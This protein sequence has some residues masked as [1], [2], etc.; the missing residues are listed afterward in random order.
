VVAP[1][2]F[3]DSAT[4]TPDAVPRLRA[5]VEQYLLACGLAGEIVG[6]VVLSVS[7]ALT[8]VVLHAYPAGK[9]GPVHV[10][11]EIVA[12][13]VHVVV[14]DEGR[15]MTPR[16]DSPGAGLGLPIIAKLASSVEIARVDRGTQLRMSFEIARA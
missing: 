10:D 3:R 4:A 14:A 8:N 15:G 11:T 13:V 16:H 12:G 9:A 5:A 7:E 1:A 2:P 6:A